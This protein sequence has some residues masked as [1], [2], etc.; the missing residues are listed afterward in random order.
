M[1]LKKSTKSIKNLKLP[2]WLEVFIIARKELERIGRLKL[3]ILDRQMIR[4]ANIRKM[5]L[6]KLRRLIK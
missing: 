3:M 1:N 5:N 2:L 4:Q 6:R